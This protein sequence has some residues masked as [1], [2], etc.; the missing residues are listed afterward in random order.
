[1][2]VTSMISHT[3]PVA[4]GDPAVQRA[5]RKSQAPESDVAEIWD[6]LPAVDAY[7]LRIL[8]L[9][10]VAVLAA[11]LGPVQEDQRIAGEGFAC[12]VDDVSRAHQS[13]VSVTNWAF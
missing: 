6:S 7:E 5:C 4:S 3:L 13:S 9:S 10:L 8:A 1:M 12:Y 11:F 2:S